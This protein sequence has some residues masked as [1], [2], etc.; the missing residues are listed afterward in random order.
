MYLGRGITDTGTDEDDDEEN[1]DSA[2]EDDHYYDESPSSLRHMTVHNDSTTRQVQQPGS[3]NVVVLLPKRDDS[4]REKATLTA[5]FD[6]PSMLE[7]I[8]SSPNSSPGPVTISKPLGSSGGSMVEVTTDELK[9][10]LMAAAAAGGNGMEVLTPPPSISGDSNARSTPPEAGTSD[11]TVIEQREA[12]DLSVTDQQGSPSIK[13]SPV[14]LEQVSPHRGAN[15]SDL[16]FY[17]TTDKETSTGD[18]AVL[19]DSAERIAINALLSLS[20]ARG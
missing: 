9:Y 3:G 13:A 16:Y 4:E 20:K 6:Y 15:K 11:W 14:I 2:R 18:D 17:Q 5:H 7:K 10:K 12:L 1:E 19:L 8:L